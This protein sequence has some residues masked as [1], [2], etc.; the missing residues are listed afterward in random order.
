MKP[1][2]ETLQSPKNTLHIYTRVST[3]VQRDEGTSLGTQLE[4]G[5]K[6]AASLG[7]HHKVWDEGGKSSSHEEVTGRPK[8]AALYKAIQDGEVKHL[9]VYDQSRLSRSDGVASAFRY[10]CKSKGVRLYTKDGEFDLGNSTDRLLTQ[11]LDAMAEFENSARVDRS[12]T[13][14][15]AR[16]KEGYW[17]GGKAPF[18]YSLSGRRLK[19]N[20][21]EARWVRYIFSSR[22]N[23]SSIAAIKRKLDKSRIK[24][25]HSK[26][27]SLRS[28]TI[29]LRSTRYWGTSTIKDSRNGEV[30]EVQSPAIISRR[31]WQKAQRTL[32][33]KMQLAVLSQRQKQLALFGGVG[34]CGH[35]GRGI[36][37]RKSNHSGSYFYFCV[38]RQRDW[39]ITAMSTH[40]YKHARGCGFYRGA[41]IL[42]IDEQVLDLV[43][44]AFQSPA[45]Y[46]QNLAR[47]GFTGGQTPLDPTYQKA[48]QER[49]TLLIVEQQL[50]S[51]SKMEN[52]HW[53]AGKGRRRAIA[54]ADQWAV[55]ASQVVQ[56]IQELEDEKRALDTYKNFEAWFLDI[57][58]RLQTVSDLPQDER[59]TL[60]EAA[61]VGVAIHN[62]KQTRGHMIT[63]KFRHM[64]MDELQVCLPPLKRVMGR[65][66]RRWY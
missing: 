7:F 4:A 41:K 19:I 63:V 46:W 13:G 27:F 15:L 60:L 6:R 5:I 61:V 33:K 24:P 11:I 29:L 39:K 36:G 62:I 9:Y 31:I 59:R 1:K 17:F 14:R 28:L 44:Q 43:Q 66:M 26:R 42:D 45:P 10:L 21:R 52:R 40:Y 56:Q 55:R 57:Q 20:Q 12:L 65:W 49:Y 8:L 54:S 32:D 22:A 2:T 38:A 64:L 58:R 25:R 16:A 23:G 18:G 51:N 35:C 47:A 50:L 48:I 34:Y 53:I 3:L 37:I 30:I